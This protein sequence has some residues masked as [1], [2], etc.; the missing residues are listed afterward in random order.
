M[1]SRAAAA[2]VLT[3]LIAAVVAALVVG[4]LALVKVADLAGQGAKAR[5]RQMQVFPVSLKVYE[6]AYARGKI[7]ADDL[8]CFK[9][10]RKCP[11]VPT[12]TP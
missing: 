6:D 9:S 3:F 10:G 8:T 2:V 1:R 11:P 5:D 4:V 7:T 12:R